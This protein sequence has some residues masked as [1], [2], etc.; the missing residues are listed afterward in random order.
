MGGLYALLTLAANLWFSLRLQGL[1]LR[2]DAII[3]PDRKLRTIS[4][5]DS[6][7]R[8]ASL[9]PLDRLDLSF[10]ALANLLVVWDQVCMSDGVTHMLSKLGCRH[11]RR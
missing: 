5:V 10:A 8:G 2:E 4:V 1:V 6:D 11:R 7:A 9:L 3:V